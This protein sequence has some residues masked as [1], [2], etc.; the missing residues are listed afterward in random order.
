MPYGPRRRFMKTKE[1]MS[2]PFK[3]IAA[4]MLILFG[5]IG[6]G[7]ALAGSLNIPVRVVNTL[8]QDRALDPVSAGIPIPREQA[9]TSTQ[10]LA[11]VDESG[12]QVPCQFQ[13]AARW[14]G[15]P[16]DASKPAKWVL[17]TFLAS[18]PSRGESQYR[19]VDK[20]G[21][22]NA[23]GITVT[24]NNDNS[25]TIDTG[26]AVFT[27]NRDHFTLFDKVTSGG[28][29][30]TSSSD[31]KIVL[32]DE[33]G[34]PYST[35]N[36]KPKVFEIEEQGPVR[37]VLRIEGSLRDSSL[38][39]L[40][41]YRAYLYFYLEKSYVRILFTLGNHRK[42][43][44][45]E[46]GKYDVYDYYG[47]N[48]VTFRDLSAVMNLEDST[49]Q[50][51]YLF[52]GSSGEISGSL[53]GTILIY[54]DSSGTDFWD[55]YTA[56]D[57]PRPTSYCRFRGYEAGLNSSKLDSGDKFAG[58]MDLS[59]DDRG[60]SAGTA[61]FWQE[62]PKALEATNTGVI[63]IKLLPE[64]YSG[65]YNFRVGEEK[66]SEFFLYF[67]HGNAAASDAART[68]KSILSPMAAVMPLESYLPGQAIQETAAAEDKDA[69]YSRLYSEL[70]GDFTRL[71]LPEMYD[72]YNDRTI[73]EDVNYNGPYSTYYPF[74]SLWKSSERSPS[75]RDYFNFFGA[76]GCGY[77]NLPLDYESYG[78]GK[79]GPFDSKYD[80]DYGAWLQFLRKGDL[81]WR[82]MAQAI[83]KYSEQ[84]M[85]HDVVTETGWDIERWKNAVF[86]HAEHNETGNKNGQ[87]NY[88][89]PVLDTSFGAPGALL[90]YYLTGYPVS[91]IFL[92]K[93]SDYTYSFYMQDGIPR[94]TRG[95]AYENFI[96]RE[97]TSGGPEGVNPP[98][99]E[100]A[101]VINH[102][103]AGFLLTGDKRY[104]NLIQGLIEYYY[105]DPEKEEWSWLNGPDPSKDPTLYINEWNLVMYL[106]AM[107]WYIGALEE[108]GLSPQVAKARTIFMRFIDW[109][110]DYA[111]GQYDPD[112][113]R[114]IT[115]TGI[116]YPY[117][118][119]DGHTPEDDV[120]IC[121]W[122]YATADVF[123]YAYKYTGKR[124]YLDL[125][126]ELFFNASMN[127]GYPGDTLT[128]MT[129]KEAANAAVF[130]HVYL[131]Y[132]EDSGLPP[133]ENQP[134]VADAGS[135]ITA[136]EGEEVVLDG[137]GSHDPDGDTLEFR[138]S[139]AP[140][141]LVQV[142]I[143]EQDSPEARFTAPEVPDGTSLTL[144]FT[145]AVNDGIN[146]EVTDSVEVVVS[147]NQTPGPGSPGTLVLQDGMPAGDIPSYQGTTDAYIRIDSEGNFG[148]SQQLVAYNSLAP[149]W[150]FF[151][152]FD[153]SGLEIPEDAHID[154]ARLMLTRTQQSYNPSRRQIYRLLHWWKE[155]S[156]TYGEISDGVTWASYDGTSPW[157]EPGGDFDPE[158]VAAGEIVE[159]GAPKEVETYDIT[160]LARGWISGSMENNGLMVAIPEDFYYSASFY[161]SRESLDISCRPRLEIRYSTQS[162]PNL[163]MN[164]EFDNGL[165]GWDDS[166]ADGWVQDMD[167]DRMFILEDGH[168]IQNIDLS[169]YSDKI[170]SG[171]AEL[172]IR[173]TMK[174]SDDNAEDGFPYIRCVLI[175]TEQDPERINTYLNTEY[176]PSTT[177]KQ[178]QT[179][180]P[181][182]EH[183][184]SLRLLLKKT[185]FAGSNSTSRYAFFDSISITISDSK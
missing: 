117:W 134:P 68:S 59:S 2:I 185:A 56:A 165:Q 25:I 53:N 3:M 40:L 118:Y 171:R 178:V 160:S 27:L 92:E 172:I 88:L 120:L 111:L 182:P 108:Y 78:D 66:T 34:R 149:A 58:W 52:P 73:I 116:Y 26:A 173:G 96:G 103:T 86:G 181:V 45:G 121:N 166:W 151:I 39:P 64:D 57:I 139:Q 33:S 150:R 13:V 94:Y 81:D 144:H 162:P 97:I 176:V 46:N 85:L 24:E 99:R 54:Q 22:V 153:L 126:R 138:W 174:S 145:L 143:Q 91:R 51:S 67:H 84:L 1:A 135:D 11:M 62:F 154:S 74:H 47:Q 123:A 82:E 70:D 113:Y 50:I 125:A 128:Y 141:D 131:Y 77:G 184:G 164:P 130:G 158:P 75:S 175:G 119:L 142:V 18:V 44:V 48:S 106:H 105:P 107:G 16:D 83:S 90:S 37:L 35:I 101:N 152:R 115:Y 127:Q 170:K 9:V 180:V 12:R 14:G 95:G 6:C 110:K 21:A 15:S 32:T 8:S 4:A 28:A 183:T 100:M 29:V 31:N 43:A 72:Y 168:L 80:I 89:G 42:A 38:S 169:G 148:K 104:Q 55:N 102:L 114:D 161:C 79:A 71:T 30:I 122:E 76:L 136:R 147:R 60:I 129:A 132:A 10:S 159:P 167:D 133:D 179:S 146:Q 87:R 155:G 177:W 109:M 49:N 69:L 137:S 98:I 124:D 20:G 157:N 156:G 140:E 23:E 7:S 36:D 93:I 5:I 41:D 112:D 19:L 65:L 163:V 17:A 63:K 61:N